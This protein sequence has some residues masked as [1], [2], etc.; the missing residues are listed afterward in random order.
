MVIGRT[1]DNKI[2]I[3]TNGGLRIVECSCCQPCNNPNLKGYIA[4]PD[5]SYNYFKFLKLKYAFKLRRT[6]IAP[7]TTTVIEQDYEN[8]IIYK[9]KNAD[10]SLPIISATGSGLAVTTT[11]YGTCQSKQT[12]TSNIISF[13]ELG[14]LT[15]YIVEVLQN[16]CQGTSYTYE[17]EQTSGT[18]PWTRPLNS[19]PPI[20]IT[21]IIS[22]TE[23]TMI[24]SN[25]SEASN[26]YYY[27]L[28]NE[29]FN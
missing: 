20:I 7:F 10:C 22:E 1:N 23:A 21:N 5:G 25:S 19:I 13:T 3:K 12:I 14:T 4:K 17:Y 16:D 26:T 27:Y 2:N 6:V 18:P 28:S 15:S 29:P 11:S 24:I 8:I 9:V